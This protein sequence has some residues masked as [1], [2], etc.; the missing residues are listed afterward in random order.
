MGRRPGP[1][2]AEFELYRNYRKA[3]PD[4]EEFQPQTRL[5]RSSLDKSNDDLSSLGHGVVEVWNGVLKTWNRLKSVFHGQ[6]H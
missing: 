3:T 5:K 1:T 4:R 6:S 2:A